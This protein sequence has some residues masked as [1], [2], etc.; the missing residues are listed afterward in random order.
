MSPYR[1]ST[2]KLGSIK[3]VIDRNPWPDGPKGGG[4]EG[5]GTLDPGAKGLY[6]TRRRAL[7]LGQ[8]RETQRRA[9]ASR[10]KEMESVLREVGQE[11]ACCSLPV[12]RPNDVS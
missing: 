12:Q 1:T 5:A 10:A 2:S 11:V 6:S 3:D 8:V 7:P 9:V 4:A